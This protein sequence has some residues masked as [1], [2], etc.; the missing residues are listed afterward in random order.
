ML[1][2]INNKLRHYPQFASA[3]GIHC[4]RDCDG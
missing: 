3:I 4:V 1:A 2:A